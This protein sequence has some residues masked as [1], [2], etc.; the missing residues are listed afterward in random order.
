MPPAALA[1][2]ARKRVEQR[3]LGVAILLVE[4]NARAALQIADS[5]YVLEM[6]RITLAGASSALAADGRVVDLY[7]GRD[8]G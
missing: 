1:S 4:Q 3:R 8:R 5:G 6:G 2:A 7:L